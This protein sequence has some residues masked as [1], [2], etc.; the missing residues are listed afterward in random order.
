EAP[1]DIEEVRKR[2]DL[3]QRFLLAVGHL[4]TRKNYARLIEAFALLAERYGEL[5]L[6][7]VGNESGEGKGIAARIRC[8]GLEGRVCLLHDVNDEELAAIYALS[9]MVVF[10][11]TYEGFGIPVIE[12]MA[13]SRPLACS[14]IAVFRELT[15]GQAAYFDPLDSAA[16]ASAIGALLTDKQRQ[17]TFTDYGVKRLASFSFPNLARQIEAIDRSLARK[18]AA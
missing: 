5:G 7:I 3:P 6:V 2:L 15:E 14:D 16:M 8:L 4:E 18:A 12:A 9:C 10:P 11:S 17:K 13:A 1:G